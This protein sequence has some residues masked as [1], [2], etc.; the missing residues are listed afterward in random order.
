MRAAAAN[1]ADNS[2]AGAHELMPMTSATLPADGEPVSF[3]LPPPAAASQPYELTLPEDTAFQL[4]TL[5]RRVATREVIRVR[6]RISP[7]GLPPLEAHTIDLS[8]HGLAVT[9]AQPLNVDHECSVELGISVPE[10]A[11]PPPL[12]ASVRYCARLREDQYRIGMKFTTVSVEAAELL[13]AVL[14]L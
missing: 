3:E 6:A 12:R 2:D 5:E 10:L 9:S 1:C 14:G 8:S 7:D 11:P 4:A 13:V